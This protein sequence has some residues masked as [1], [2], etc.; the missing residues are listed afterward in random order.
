QNDQL[1]ICIAETALR[2]GD[3][4]DSATQLLMSPE[5]AHIDWEPENI[6]SMLDPSFG[7]FGFRNTESENSL[8]SLQNST[9]KCHLNLSNEIQTN[10]KPHLT[11]NSSL[12]IEKPPP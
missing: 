8:S 7:T 6:F 11:L 2:S 12:A 3:I 1:L 5:L 9:S 4:A 10:F